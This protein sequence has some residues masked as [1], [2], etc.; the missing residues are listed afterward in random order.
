[1][2]IVGVSVHSLLQG[3]TTVKE[4]FS[5]SADIRTVANHSSNYLRYISAAELP[6]TSSTCGGCETVVRSSVHMYILVTSLLDIDK[7]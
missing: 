3:V 1:M 2:L 5:S 6:P 4:D 7:S